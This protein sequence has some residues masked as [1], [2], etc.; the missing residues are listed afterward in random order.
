MALFGV[1]LSF[2]PSSSSL[3][4]SATYEGLQR[5][6]LVKTSEESEVYLTPAYLAFH[7]EYELTGRR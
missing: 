5:E 7:P 4:G 2:T 1:G 6:S 3:S